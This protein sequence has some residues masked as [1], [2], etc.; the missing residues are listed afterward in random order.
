M[1][2][3]T[4]PVLMDAIFPLYLTITEEDRVAVQCSPTNCVIANAISRQK[5]V[6]DQRVGASIVRVLKK[7]GWVRYELDPN[8]MNMIYAYDTNGQVM[9][10]GLKV[11]LLPPTSQP[12][13]KRAGTRSGT[14]TRSGAGTSVATRRPSSR[15]ILRDVPLD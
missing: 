10:A 9:P 6:L 11:K 12:I 15:H 4:P 8:T 3:T 14:K 13:G 5:G 2:I 7:D 1:T